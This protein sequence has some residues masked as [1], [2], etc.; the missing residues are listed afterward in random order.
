MNFWD[1]SAVVALLVDELGSVSVGELRVRDPALL[2][3]WATR[4]ECASAIARLQREQALN[5]GEGERAQTDLSAL[6]SAWGEV[7]PTTA[8]RDR[9]ILYTARHSLRAADALQL[10]AA[11]V[12]L[13]AIGAHGSAFV[14]LDRRL[15]AAARTEG[16]NV[17][18]AARQPG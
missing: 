11:S 16:L 5:A 2:V 1:T 9:A 18:P 8:V 15:A 13:S 3:W 6:A 17:F 7:E 12:G 4:V 14:C 10:A